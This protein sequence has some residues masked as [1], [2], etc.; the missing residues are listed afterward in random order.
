M[1]NLRFSIAAGETKVFVIAGRYL[2]IIDATGPVTIGLYDK[3]G[4]QTDDAKDILSGTYM[5]GEFSQF[6]IFSATAQTIEL[7]LTQTGGGTRRQ[8]GNVRVID[9]SA[10]QTAALNQ[11]LAMNS[12]SDGAKGV[13]VGLWA[14]TKPITIRSLQFGSNTTTAMAV[15]TGTTRPATGQGAAPAPT[16]KMVGSA[17]ATSALAVSGTMAGALPVVAADLP[18]V[19]TVGYIN[20]Q[21]NQLYSFPLKTPIV[22]PAG[23]FFGFAT[24]AAGA[25]VQFTAEIEE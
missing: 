14:Q 21:A 18:G 9:Q 1:Q 4:S 3:A 7:F 25:S 2:E 15:V 8:P 17:A 13:I 6:E 5:Q 22:I 23:R 12:V 20:A 19:A 11:F 24:G 10:D 16:N